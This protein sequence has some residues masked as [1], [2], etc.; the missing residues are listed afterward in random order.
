MVTSSRTIKVAQPIGRGVHWVAAL[1]AI[2][3]ICA[4]TPNSPVLTSDGLTIR[5]GSP[6]Y[7]HLVTS[8]RN[9]DKLQQRIS[10][11]EISADSREAQLAFRQMVIDGFGLA[12]ANCS[13]FFHNEG[14]HQQ[15]VIF[16]R[17]VVGA[18][19]TLATAV[20]AA[21]G[22]PTGVIAGFSIATATGYNGLDIYQRNFLFGAENIDSVR[23]LI[24]KASA[25]RRDAVLADKGQWQ[26]FGEAQTAVMQYQ[27]EC[28]PA[29]ILSHTRA[30]IKNADALAITNSASANSKQVTIAISAPAKMLTNTSQ[31][32]ATIGPS[33]QERI[34]VEGPL[35]NRP[36]NSVIFSRRQ[37]LFDFVR[38]AAA[39]AE[40]NPA[41]FENS[42][43]RKIAVAI[44]APL[45][46]SVPTQRAKI[47]AW[48][49]SSLQGSDDDM[50]E[51]LDTFAT[52]L[53]G[54][55]IHPN[56]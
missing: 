42:Q 13:D 37:A 11:A 24:E 16:S 38:K 40:K 27:E 3:G 21:A 9:A 43:L 50:K 19:G 17:D 30:A 52:K 36:L 23:L 6:A 49:A 47:I 4:C 45:S 26:D 22:S 55:G 12:D 20:T 2:P 31:T 32:R 34:K 14:K 48:I 25:A 51:E 29:S 15:W 10:N 33:T 5:D 8:Y 41:D 1:S 39:D 56:F 53:N 28:M 18:V 46:E 35:Q 44:G 7:T 54:A